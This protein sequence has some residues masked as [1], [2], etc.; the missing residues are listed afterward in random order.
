MEKKKC[1]LFDRRYGWVYDEWREP[2]EEALAGGRGMFCIVP[3]AKG[4]IQTASHSVWIEGIGKRNSLWMSLGCFLDDAKINAASS[5]VIRVIESPE[6]L[7]SQKLQAGLGTELSR[8]MVHLRQPK[9]K[10]QLP[11]IGSLGLGSESHSE[12]STKSQVS[13]CS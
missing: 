1:L 2:S 9:M 3:L 7:S 8:L 5:S 12:S 10:L 11:Y 13:E 4:F 6:L